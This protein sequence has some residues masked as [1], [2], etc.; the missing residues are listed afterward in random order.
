MSTTT[1]SD[2]DTAPRGTYTDQDGTTHYVLVDKH[3]DAWTVFDTTEDLTDIRQIERLVSADDLRSAAEAV[4]DEY[5]TQMRR[6]LAGER[7]RHTV[8]HPAPK[9]IRVEFTNKRMPRALRALQP[10]KG[11]PGRA[12]TPP[13]DQGVLPVAA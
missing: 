3:L 13:D 2:A 11:R 5:L 10:A 7:D 8:P 1:L 9:A 4:G 12:T 6:Y